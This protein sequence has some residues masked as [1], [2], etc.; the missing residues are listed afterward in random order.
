MKIDLS[1]SPQGKKGIK[2]VCRRKKK[3]VISSKNCG[4]RNPLKGYHAP[5][6]AICVTLTSLLVGQSL[7]RR[8]TEII[9][10]K[11]LEWQGAVLSATIM[12]NVGK[13][14]PFQ[15]TVTF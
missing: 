12:A 5:K 9:E 2:R 10:G 11:G 7:S 6:G 8:A 14:A 15:S 1:T 4:S 3:F 13:I